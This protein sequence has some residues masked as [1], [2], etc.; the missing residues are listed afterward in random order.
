MLNRD[1][2]KLTF[3]VNSSHY[4]IM[5]PKGWT[6]RILIYHINIVRTIRK[7]THTEMICRVPDISVLYVRLN[8]YKHE[9]RNV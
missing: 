9:V 3:D 1:F 4:L 5:G 7:C 8:L 2:T 6:S